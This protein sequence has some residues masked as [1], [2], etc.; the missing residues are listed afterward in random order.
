MLLLPDT[1]F[2]RVKGRP[3]SNLEPYDNAWIAEYIAGDSHNCSM[4]AQ[5]KGAAPPSYPAGEDCM[6][7]G[8]LEAI[9]LAKTSSVAPCDAV[10][11]C[12]P[13]SVS[14]CPQNRK[15]FE[16]LQS[17]HLPTGNPRGRAHGY[18][19]P[20]NWAGKYIV[21]KCG[22]PRLSKL[23]PNY[24]PFD[25]GRCSAVNATRCADSVCCDDNGLGFRPTIDKLLA[26]DTKC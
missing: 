3:E 17:Y 8:K 1:S 25:S 23:V 6:W 21:D 19:I 18:A 26:E 5:P 2:D 22:A 16:L 20:W 11:G 9:A 15:V 14:C 12:E 10:D 24:Q 4:P 13:T 7:S